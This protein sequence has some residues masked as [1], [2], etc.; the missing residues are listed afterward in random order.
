[1]DI[2]ASLRYARTHEW[3]SELEA[4][5]MTVGITDFAQD[6]LGDVVYVELPEEGARVAAGDAVAVV[7]SVKTASDIYAPVAG[8]VKAVNAD[9]ESAPEAINEEPYGGGWLFRIAPD[10]ASD[11]EALL[12]ADAYRAVCEEES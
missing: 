10:D 1:M 6:Q 3:T 11:R 12:D 4:D 7:E 2:P 5:V 8:T 9:L